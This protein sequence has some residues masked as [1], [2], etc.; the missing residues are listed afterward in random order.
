MLGQTVESSVQNSYVLLVEDD[1]E[2]RSSVRELLEYE[3]F[4]VREAVN[5]QDALSQLRADS[6]LPALILLDMMMP[7]MD[8]WEFLKQ[9]EDDKLLAGIPVAVLSAVADRSQIPPAKHHLRKPVD[10]DRLINLVGS[11]CRP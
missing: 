4:N 11:Y 2:I 5:G 1:H 7:I 6:D 8:G 10:I 9:H 3:G